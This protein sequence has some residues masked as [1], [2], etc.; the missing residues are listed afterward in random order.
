[1][2][3]R[4][5]FVAFIVAWA[6]MC[7]LTDMVVSITEIGD[8][9]IFGVTIVNSREYKLLI[10]NTSQIS[11]YLIN[12]SNVT[13]N[14]TWISDIARVGVGSSCWKHIPYCV[15]GGPLEF[16]V[17]RTDTSKFIE[18][19]SVRLS[20][21]LPDFRIF[22]AH[23]QTIQLTDYYL[24]SSPLGIGRSRYDSMSTWTQL[25][26]ENKAISSLYS[27]SP[28]IAFA[29]FGSYL[30]IFNPVS[31]KSI[32]HI[33]LPFQPMKIVHTTSSM[34]FLYFDGTLTSHSLSP[35]SPTPAHSHLTAHPLH[36]SAHNSQTLLLIT[37]TTLNFISLSDLTHIHSLRMP[38]TYTHIH[39]VDGSLVGIDVI[40]SLHAMRVSMADGSVID[41]SVCVEGCLR[42]V[43]AA[44]ARGCVEC[45]DGYEE[46]EGECVRKRAVE[47]EKKEVE[48]NSKMG[49]SYEDRYGF[50][51]DKKYYE[52]IYKTYVMYA[53]AL[54]GFGATIFF[55][56]I[57]RIAYRLRYRQLKGKEYPP[58]AT[59]EIT[60]RTR[61]TTVEDE[62]RP[63]QRSSR[64]VVHED[65]DDANAY[66]TSSKA[67]TKKT[68]TPTQNAD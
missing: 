47:E 11:M 9:S 31:M 6:W 32:S 50:T 40:G 57:Q 19:Y 59:R 22:Q 65:Q 56:V 18:S 42:C 36:I 15:L 45:Q 58:I 48:K 25:D 39:T 29:T 4:K 17:F 12:S 34:I 7:V 49:W 27:D 24:F 61:I 16:I 14:D 46:R 41:S 28:D 37:H 55:S 54:G 43:D 35:T 8:H 2:A 66:L 1:M 51:I 30:E 10:G 33:D 23:I 20:T 60:T 38:H 13:L 21:P 64:Q 63:P 3:L 44:S 67:I 52:N 53:L 62:D 68:E 5:I 26:L